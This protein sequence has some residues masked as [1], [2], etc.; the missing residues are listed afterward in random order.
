MQQVFQMRHFADVPVLN[1]PALPH[2]PPA[3]LAD[4]EIQD[5]I[6]VITCS[7][8]CPKTLDPDT[9]AVLCSCR[10]TGVLGG[11][12]HKQAVHLVPLH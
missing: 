12:G 9:G 5:T 2:R 7:Y 4:P 6:T 11:S 1:G 8:A 10:R 3:Y